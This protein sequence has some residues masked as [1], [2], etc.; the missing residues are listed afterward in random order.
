MKANSTRI[1]QCR[2]IKSDGERCKANAARDSDLCFFHDPAKAGERA[3]ARRAGGEKGRAAVLPPGTP[4]A[5]L[6]SIADVAAVIGQ[7]IN[8]VRRGEVDP[9][10]ANA[11]GYLAGVLLKAL[12]VGEVERRLEALEEIVNRRPAADPAGEVLPLVH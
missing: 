8:Q 4:D 2:H 12:E 7:T 1:R 10:V 11:V 5:S 6:G 3:A 9:R